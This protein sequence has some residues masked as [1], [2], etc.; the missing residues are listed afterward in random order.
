MG[1]FSRSARLWLAT[2]TVILGSVL[3]TAQ[4][5]E[6][7]P[8]RIMMVLDG[9]SSMWGQ[10]NGQ[11]KISVAADVVKDVSKRW[12]DKVE[13]GLVTYG[14]RRRSDCTDIETIVKLRAGNARQIT[15]AIR[16]IKPRGKTPLSAAVLHAAREI[17]FESR[18]SSIVLI[19]DGLENCGLDPCEVARY[20]REN[21]LDFRAHV[22]GYDLEDENQS[23]LRCLADV[24]GGVYVEAKDEQE[25]KQALKT[26]VQKEFRRDG[27]D[28]LFAALS[29]DQG[30]LRKVK[31]NWRIFDEQVS[32]P[33]IL[34]GRS[35]SM[36]LNL[37]PGIYMVE[38]SLGRFASY[39]QVEILGDEVRKHV[40]SLEMG[41]MRLESLIEPLDK[42]EKPKGEFMWRVSKVGQAA[43]QD[44]R[45]G[46]KTNFFLPK[47]DY[48]VTV[49]RDDWEQSRFIT[50]DSGEIRYEHF[51]FRFGQI[52][53]QTT[54]AKDAEVRW[55]VHE[56][57]KDGKDGPLVASHK[58]SSLSTR[59][60][61][62]NYIVKANYG[63]SS[64]IARLSLKV[65][66]A[67]R[68]LLK[69]DSGKLA[70][71]AKAA[72]GNTPV[73]WSIYRIDREQGHPL[74]A[75]REGAEHKLALADG[76]YRI[77]ARQG[78]T[79]A[80]ATVAVKSGRSTPL[81]FIMANDVSVASKS[82]E[83]AQWR[84]IEVDDQGAESGE[85]VAKQ[86]AAVKTRL[87]PGRYMVIGVGKTQEYRKTFK[88]LPGK[89]VNLIIAGSKP[90]KADVV[91]KGKAPKAASK[92]SAVKAKPA[93]KASKGTPTKSGST[94]VAS[95]KRSTPPAAV[96]TSPVKQPVG[97]AAKTATSKA[98]RPNKETE[99]A[100]LKREAQALLAS[101]KPVKPTKAKTAAKAKP[102][103]SA[104]NNF[105]PSTKTNKP[106]GKAS[107]M[108]KLQLQANA[109]KNGKPVVL[110]WTIYKIRSG[111][112]GKRVARGI[113]ARK[114]FQ[115]LP[116]RYRVMARHNR[117]MHELDLL[118]LPG[119]TRRQTLVLNLGTLFLRAID[120]N[121]GDPIPVEWSVHAV[122]KDGK[123]GT[124]IANAISKGE[125]YELPKGRY[126]L[127]VADDKG[128]RTSTIVIKPGER[129]EKI[130]P[131]Q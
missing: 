116:G 15:R 8:A 30:I 113:G 60:R 122:T 50:I 71:K 82:S 131:V 40:I 67:K 29:S 74:V 91:T 3:S 85:I 10:I 101:G 94:S 93:A 117:S 33:P 99:A 21:G 14:H 47:G 7:P 20:L 39:S 25:L 41:Q 96:R 107:V 6:V 89:A 62:G 31:I 86:G 26:V 73:Q 109:T 120:A 97:A 52:N 81:S 127:K 114:E 5:E 126:L 9:S 11:P 108:A 111:K 98:K 76:R 51:D 2:S 18:R 88:V 87:A 118:L 44:M 112:L 58:G 102:G 12:S 53:F 129:V 32:G 90:Q 65:G 70:L 105:K 110:S 34:V 69:F 37:E 68:E 48:Q 19:T 75:E 45:R 92:P 79:E 124:R 72:E 16:K 28:T 77:H 115:L 55:L 22:V 95:I 130:F 64:K 83:A 54:L 35:E 104:D 56:Q 121:S 13:L 84:F 59:V 66:E 78:R 125:E 57:T 100:R 4:A 42:D 106:K 17:G 24:T 46:R 103:K 1:L 38:A 27:P 80:E 49:N 63:G 61:P 36:K 119:Q 23:H 123:P 43:G 128:E